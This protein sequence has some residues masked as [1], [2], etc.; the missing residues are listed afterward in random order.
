MDGPLRLLFCGS[1]WLPVVDCIRAGLPA[2]D[3]LRVWDRTRPL[4]DEVGAIDVLLPSNG[5]ITAAVIA[6]APHLRLIQQPAAGHDKIDLAAARAAGV[7]VCN[8]PGANHVAVAE[9]AIFLLL[10]CARRLPAAQAAFA[11]VAI[12]VP[13]GVELAG[14][15]LGV[16]G[17]GRTGRA[18]A[19]RARGLGMA[20]RE[21]GRGASADER[22]AFF[23]GC[24][25][26]SIHCPLTDASRGLIGREALAAM[27]P[28]ALLVNVARG[29]VID[30]D[31]LREALATDRLGGV[32]LD[33]V[34]QEPWDPTDPL[35]HHPRVVVLPHVAG[36]TDEAFA[37]IAG[38][39][40][41]NVTRLRRGEVLQ[42][43]VA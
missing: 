18:V 24:D 10:A 29:A 9:A 28:G 26:F 4:T 11:R 2:A 23:A 38:I 35:F 16:I 21:L 25:A 37:R 41:D 31:A 20:V 5:I 8:A 22:A 34:W 14:R 27:R 36:S 39:V 30:Q 32:G 17:P 40:V 43:R 3:T 13:L 12:G 1:G 42:H 6:A 15:T 7:P 33:V 19:E